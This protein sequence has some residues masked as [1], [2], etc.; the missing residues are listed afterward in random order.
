EV[1]RAIA[2]E[3]QGALTP[4]E[5][6][7]LAEARPVN[8]E[9]YDAYL[10]GSFYWKAFAPEDLDTAQRYFEL[11]L[12]KDPSYAEAYAGVAWVWA[13][14]Q[15]IGLAPPDEGGPKVKTAALRAIELDEGSA[16][17]HAALAL[18][19]GMTDW[20]RA[21]AEE[22]YRRALEIDPNLAS[23][24]AAFAHNLLIM[25][26]ID[27]AV[28]HSERAIELDPFNA[29]YHSLYAMVLSGARRYDDALAAARTALAMDPGMV[30]AKGALAG[31]FFSKG[32]RDEHLA[33][34]REDFAGDQTFG[35][36]PEKLA[37][38][39][40]G[41]AEAGYEGAMRRAADLLV[42]RYES[43]VPDRWARPGQIAAF[44]MW[45]G[46]HDRSIEWYERAFEIHDPFM[47]YAGVLPLFDPLRSDPRFQDLLRRMNLPVSSG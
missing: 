20:D 24:H 41:F 36:D 8:P 39:D 26:R 12:E 37:A 45:A 42:A 14:R 28:Q 22:E 1:A 13:V 43:G 9:A 11:A 15:Q 4:E 25:G 46:D 23:A 5:T 47:G 35:R 17:A 10:K 19:R 38:L 21:A 44:Y 31:V 29:L 34:V 18:A 40:Q 27:E 30:S 2:G 16:R 7:R 33:M 32:M 3:L 6:S